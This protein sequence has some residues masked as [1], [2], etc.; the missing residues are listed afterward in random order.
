MKSQALA[1]NIY[2]SGCAVKFYLK[3]YLALKFC[4]SELQIK[5]QE[6]ISLLCTPRN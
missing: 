5:D 2:L 4:I 6:L 3:C 1:F